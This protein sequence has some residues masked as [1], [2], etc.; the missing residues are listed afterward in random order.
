MPTVSALPSLT[1]QLP[2]LLP[3]LVVAAGGVAVLLADAF[4]RAA[5]R[6]HLYM[7]S[8]L[9]MLGALAAQLVV[10]PVT[11][12]LL[13]GM[14]S[15]G[16]YARFFNFL[17][18]GIA[19]LTATF[20]T[21]VFEREGRW[22]SEFYPLLIFATLGM[23]ILAAATDLLALFLGLETMSLAVYV[24]VGGRRG[25]LR[26]TEAGLKYLLLGAFASAFL[27]FGLGLLYGFAG[28]TDYATIAGAVADPGRD[29][30]L[31][32]TAL[33][34]ILVGFGFK[35]ALVPFHMW[36]PDVY[37][38][39][40]AYVTG[41]MAT[42]V[43][44]AAFA[45]LLRFAWLAV[46]PLA[47]FWFPLL[48]ALAVLTMTMGNLVALAQDS[49]KRLL[50]WSSIAHAG[51]LMLG[52][53]ALLAPARGGEAARFAGAVVPAAGG[54]VLF[55]LVAYAL[56]NLGAF[57]VVSLL[58]RGQDEEADRIA[59][60]AGLSRRQPLAAAALAVCMFSLA[61]IPPTAGFMGKFY[62]FSTV[63]KAGLVPL[64]IWGVINSL[65]SVY[66]YLRVVVVMYMQSPEGETVYDGR[67]WESLFGVGMIALLLLF[68][69]VWPGGLQRLAEA[70]FRTLTG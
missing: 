9:V 17:F 38:G 24:L 43:K 26:G 46:A 54:A 60:Y 61:G 10:P 65:L 31:L 57:G 39:A 48:A 52:V 15:A 50:A 13:G 33:G 34:L 19:L 44:A 35:I 16:P 14:L 67:S 58:G 5:R 7:L 18:L 1:A 11:E 68:L 32:L 69:G 51:Y 64:A 30:L 23:M 55:Y 3:Y 2:A 59:G 63:V 4:T 6:D 29:R 41:Y 66:F 22:R 27:L 56:M 53:L 62:I 12:G 42:G 70:T 20:A 21:S 37:D 8:V 36:T 25:S 45:A 40:A 28:A 49:L 47:G